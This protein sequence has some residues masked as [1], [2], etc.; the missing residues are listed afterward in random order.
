ME[1]MNIFVCVGCFLKTLEG[2]GRGTHQPVFIIWLIVSKLWFM[3]TVGCGLQLI[4][5]TLSSLIG[6]S[7]QKLTKIA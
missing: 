4:C 2:V 7:G 3:G 5:G 1:N 6:I